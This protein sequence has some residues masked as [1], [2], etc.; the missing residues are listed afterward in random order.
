M[1]LKL[2]HMMHAYLTLAIPLSITM[3][4][5]GIV[6]EVSAMFVAITI[7]RQPYIKSLNIVSTTLH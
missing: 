4:M 5:P 3:L 2:G 6:N 1:I 7:F